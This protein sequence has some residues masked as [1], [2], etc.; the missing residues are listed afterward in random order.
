MLMYANFSDEHHC[1]RSEG[2]TDTIDEILIQRGGEPP[3]DWTRYLVLDPGHA[4]CALLFAAVP[5]PSH[6]YPDTV[7]CYDE[8]YL[9][10]M[11]ANGVAR[12]VLK[13]ASGMT[14][15]AFLIDNRAGR[16]TPMGFSKTV[17]QQY[18]DAFAKERIQSI[19]T[20][21]SFLPGSDNVPAGIGMVREWLHVHAGRRPRI[22]VY[23]SR[24]PWLCK[25]F[26]LYRKK[27]VRDEGKDEP[28]PKNDHLMDCLRYLAS[29][30]PVYRKPRQT[31]EQ[32]RPAYRAYNDWQKAGEK[33]HNSE[34]MTLGPGTAH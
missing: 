12:E 28:V 19:Q 1:V 23:K 24:M 17:R 20:G 31:K 29:Y 27:M 3:A 21:A 32:W 16:Q 25:E 22:R 33:E 30:N 6:L 14:F 9:R 34:H 26:V 10:Q 2:D 15:E 8:L 5:P 11:D 18:S 13:K 7:V 4:N